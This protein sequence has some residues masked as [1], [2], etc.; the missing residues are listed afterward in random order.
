MGFAGDNTGSRGQGSHG[1]AA[2][3]VSDGVTVDPET[4]CHDRCQKPAPS[5]PSH[6]G[7]GTTVPHASY[8][9]FNFIFLPAMI[10]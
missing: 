1:G 9:V 2:E 3:A 7:Q 4:A 6:Q 8:C 5:P 10:V